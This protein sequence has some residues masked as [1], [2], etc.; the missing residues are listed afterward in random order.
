ME[1]N[2]KDGKILL[3]NAYMP[4]F[5]TNNIDSQCAMYS[6][7]LGFIDSIM[8]MNLDCSFIILSDLNCNIYDTRHPFSI[9]IRDLMQKRNLVSTY[10]YMPGFDPLS[11]WSRK[12][13]SNNGADSL[14]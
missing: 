9:L 8:E 10:D 4:Y 13:K 14:T 6:D 5:D 3:I 7:T 12:G 1:L 2:D 11:S